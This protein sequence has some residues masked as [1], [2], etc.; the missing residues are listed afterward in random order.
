MRERGRDFREAAVAKNRRA[1]YV[2][3]RV[4]HLNIVLAGR[5]V[6]PSRSGEARG[7]LREDRQDLAFCRSTSAIVAS[8]IERF[9]THVHRSRKV[10][11][12]FTLEVP[13]SEQSRFIEIQIF[14]I[15]AHR[16]RE[17]Y[18]RRTGEIREEESATDGGDATG[19]EPDPARRVKKPRGQNRVSVCM[20]VCVLA[21]S[22]AV[23]GWRSY[24]RSRTPGMRSVCGIYFDML[25]GRYICTARPNTLIF[26]PDIDD[27]HYKIDFPRENLKTNLFITIIGRLLFLNNSS[28]FRRLNKF[29]CK[30]VINPD[31][32]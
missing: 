21:I 1:P 6:K 23:S 32:G 31:E 2:C 8:R 13:F 25:L 12:D 7:S 15:Q 28:T 11:K 16:W 30:S 27:S 10:A 22:V 4:M 24:V 14:L 5:N 17:K 3:A 18:E 19:R 26:L 29:S 9:A 20:C